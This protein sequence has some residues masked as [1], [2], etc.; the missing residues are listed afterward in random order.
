MSPLQIS[1]R[2]QLQTSNTSFES[3]SKSKSACLLQ[4]T[5]PERFSLSSIAL[6]SFRKEKSCFLARPIFSSMILKQDA[7]TLVKI[8]DSKKQ[9]CQKGRFATVSCLKELYGSPS[10]HYSNITSMPPLSIH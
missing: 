2:S 6:L 4:I 10:T 9:F 5:T 8:F 7:P 3:L 1:I